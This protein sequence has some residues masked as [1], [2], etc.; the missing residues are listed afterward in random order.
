MIYRVKDTNA[1]W[2]I[3]FEIKNFLFIKKFRNLCKEHMIDLK[4]SEMND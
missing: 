4:S 2:F 1:S 3:D